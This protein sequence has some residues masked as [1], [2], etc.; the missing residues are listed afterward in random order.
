MHNSRLV[1]GGKLA[2]ELGE[3]SVFCRWAEEAQADGRLRRICDHKVEVEE[4]KLPRNMLL[5]ND[6]HVIALAIAGRARL[7]YSKDRK[8][9]IDFKNPKLLSKPRGRLL[10]TANTE[11]ARRDRDRLLRDTR[12]CSNR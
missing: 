2:A 1:F 5:S 9:G 11:R 4:A 3:S 10:P 7:L 8:L 6:A 12:L